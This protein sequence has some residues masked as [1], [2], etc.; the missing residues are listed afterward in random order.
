MQ[1]TCLQ[2]RSLV[3]Q[4]HVTCSAIHTQQPMASVHG[5]LKHIRTYAFTPV[6]CVK[7]S[8]PLA[9]RRQHNVTKPM[10]A[11]WRSRA[12]FIRPTPHPIAN[13]TPSVSN[14]AGGISDA[15]WTAIFGIV[16]LGLGG[17]LYDRYYKWEV[18]PNDSST[19]ASSEC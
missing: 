4:R 15:L 13:E 9:S 5:R 8:P 17:I 1:R 7:C 12:W 11:R 6:H 14:G 2:L 10:P 18:C 3:R 16:V 19:A